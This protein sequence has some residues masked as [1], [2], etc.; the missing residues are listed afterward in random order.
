MTAYNP[1][2]P[3]YRP[4]APDFTPKELRGRNEPELMSPS[5]MPDES[6]GEFVCLMGGRKHALESATFE[7]LST[8]NPIVNEAIEDEAIAGE[9]LANDLFAEPLGRHEFTV[10]A[11]GVYLEPHSELRAFDYG[12]VLKLTYRLQ[13]KSMSTTMIYKA[14]SALEEKGLIS[15]VGKEKSSGGRVAD[16]FVV[17][18]NGRAAFRLATQNALHVRAS[19]ESVV[20]A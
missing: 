17:T 12:S 20:A 15:N 1:K 6:E 3:D 5:S 9:M 13:G 19:R 18:S 8:W 7:F 14:M 16:H 11:C 2:G 10:L 4:K